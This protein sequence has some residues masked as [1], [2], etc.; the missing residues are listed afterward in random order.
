MSRSV[1]VPMADKLL[2]T[3]GELALSWDEVRTEDI[4]EARARNAAVA[5]EIEALK[6]ADADA[7]EALA[8]RQ[9]GLVRESE[10]FFLVVN[11]R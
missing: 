3:A 4:A 5:A 10:E 11:E 9:L 2:A 1:P 6:G 8:R 7:L